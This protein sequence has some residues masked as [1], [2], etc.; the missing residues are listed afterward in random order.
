MYTKAS[1]FTP[2]SVENTLKQLLNLHVE[3][4]ILQKVYPKK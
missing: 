3:I 4:Q 1:A 2:G